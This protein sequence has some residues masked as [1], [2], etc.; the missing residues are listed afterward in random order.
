METGQNKRFCL[1]QSGLDVIKSS[2]GKD[3][4]SKRTIQTV[5][6]NEKYIGNVLLGKTYSG[7]FPNN[8][9]RKNNGEQDQFLMK[10]AHEPIIE[11]EKFD[12]VQDKIKRRSNIEMVYSKAKRKGAHYSAKREKQ[13]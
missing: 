2:Q 4:W 5:L 9:Q 1:R 6:T 7:D 8:K 11:P 10:N 13:D 12:Q 3:T